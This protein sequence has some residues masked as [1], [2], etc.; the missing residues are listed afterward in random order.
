RLGF[1]PTGATPVPRRCAASLCRAFQSGTGGGRKQVL[2]LRV[3]G[4]RAKTV[5]IG[6]GFGTRFRVPK[7][8]S[9][10]GR[11]AMSFFHEGQRPAREPILNAPASVLWL[12]AALLALHVARVMAP[13][14]W[15]DN[16]VYEY[17]FIP[18]RYS[19]GLLTVAGGSGLA[20]QLLPFLS[21]IFVHAD[22]SHVG[23]N[24]LWLLAFGPVVA[25]RIGTW[26][27]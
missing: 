11:G 6:T 14:N 27:F 12:I 7:R 13:G 3:Q 2:D 15:P 9:R 20:Q 18:A 24:C 4:R 5:Q 1:G 26:R 19:A 16:L 8:R 21:Y 17:G 25:R 22:I 10:T 23:V